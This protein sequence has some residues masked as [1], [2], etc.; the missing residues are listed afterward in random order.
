MINKSLFCCSLVAFALMALLA[1]ASADES[2]QEKKE[3]PKYCCTEAG[4][5]GP[6]NNDS[7]PEGGDCYGTKDGQRYEGKACYGKDNEE[8]KDSEDSK[9]K[10]DYP[11]YCCT[12]AG[13]L[14]PYNNDSVPE[15]GDCYG[16]KDGQRHEGKAC[17]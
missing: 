4:V 11:K 14:G 8:S 5:L 6:Y 12:D 9:E 7:V 17:Y 2:S 16:T 15:G 1:Y 3:Y 13:K 10:K